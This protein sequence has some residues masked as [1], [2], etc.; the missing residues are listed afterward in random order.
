MVLT[1]VAE[2]INYTT[3]SGGWADLAHAV[4]NLFI[5]A[6]ALIYVAIFGCAAL[7]LYLR[8]R[9]LE[10]SRIRFAFYACWLYGAAMI[11]LV[12]SGLHIYRA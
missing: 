7:V 2:Y 11:V 10:S 8:N 9:T 6:G 5:F 1:I 12:A 4:G 3:D